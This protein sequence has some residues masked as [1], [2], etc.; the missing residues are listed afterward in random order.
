MTYLLYGKDFVDLKRTTQSLEASELGYS[1]RKGSKYY[2]IVEAHVVHFS[3]PDLK[4]RVAHLHG[5]TKSKF[6][7][8]EPILWPYSRS[9]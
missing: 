2:V 6:L 4:E 3:S 1:D 8:H 9:L 5:L 7:G